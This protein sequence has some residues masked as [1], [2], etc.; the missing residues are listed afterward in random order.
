MHMQTHCFAICTSNQK[1]FNIISS[2]FP[3]CY[4]EEEGYSPEIVALSTKNKITWQGSQRLLI[5]L[6]ESVFSGFDFWFYSHF[7]EKE[8]I[9]T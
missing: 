4:F 9:I 8:A 6:L 1:L 2:Y 5:V 3:C 7:I